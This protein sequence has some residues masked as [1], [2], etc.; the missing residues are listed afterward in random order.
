MEAACCCWICLVRVRWNPER[1]LK[2]TRAFEAVWLCRIQLLTP[3]TDWQRCS[4]SPPGAGKKENTF[5][6]DDTAV[7][8]C[9]WPDV[10]NRFTGRKEY[11]TF[12]IWQPDATAGAT[13]KIYSLFFLCFLCFFPRRKTVALQFFGIIKEWII[14]WK[15]PPPPPPPTPFHLISLSSLLHTLTALFCWF[16]QFFFFWWTNPK[17]AA[18]FSSAAFSLSF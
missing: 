11:Y 16:N 15:Q 6:H 5:V 12:K 17:I 2:V 8:C 1:H 7:K 14:E 18:L 9:S 4:G 3:V 13:L 10:G